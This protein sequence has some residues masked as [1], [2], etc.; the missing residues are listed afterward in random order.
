[1]RCA[2]V[3]TLA[4]V[5][6]EL[7]DAPADLLRVDDVAQRPS[8]VQDLRNLVR[9]FLSTFSDGLAIEVWEFFLHVLREDVNLWR[10]CTERMISM[11]QWRA[12][13]G[14]ERM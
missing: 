10:M 7:V 14:R 8:R 13:S 12:T 3:V 11:A 4:L 5:A 9:N 6:V 2:T 1:M